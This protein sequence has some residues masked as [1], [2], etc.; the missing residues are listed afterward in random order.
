MTKQCPCGQTALTYT[1]LCS[2][3]FAVKAWRAALR[4]DIAE[5]MAISEEMR[6]GIHYVPTQPHIQGDGTKARKSLAL[7]S[8]LT[9]LSPV[10]LL[11]RLEQK[12]VR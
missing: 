7:A 1:T 11:R 12:K 3:C 4:A 9:G 2:H 8:Q 10:E 6:H 5:A